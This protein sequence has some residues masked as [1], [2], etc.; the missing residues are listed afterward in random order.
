M[1]RGNSPHELLDQSPGILTKLHAVFKE[2]RR[3]MCK[4]TL[5]SK[6]R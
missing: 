3:E 6:Q 4:F 1:A 5:P 2:I